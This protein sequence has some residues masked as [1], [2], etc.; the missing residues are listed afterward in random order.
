MVRRFFRWLWCQIAGHHLFGS[1]EWRTDGIH[2]R[3]CD[4]TRSAAK[5][6]KILRRP[7][8]TWAWFVGRRNNG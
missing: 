3:Y 8:G 6:D 4:W 1:A 2:C 5:C 7:P